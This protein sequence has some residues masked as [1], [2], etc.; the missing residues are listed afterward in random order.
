M[1]HY[2][3]DYANLEGAAK[4]V[5]ALKDIVDYMGW[6]KFEDLHQ[7]LLADGRKKLGQY[8]MMFSFIG[9]Q[10]YPVKAWYAHLWGDVALKEEEDRESAI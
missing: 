10:G 7:G 2:N 3:T 5:K 6:E 8:R 1:T 9:V 4:K